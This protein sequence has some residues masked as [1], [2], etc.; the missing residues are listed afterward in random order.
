VSLPLEGRP[1]DEQK[2]R[3]ENWLTELKIICRRYRILL[4][5]DDDWVHIVDMDARTTIGIGLTCLSATR[6]GRERITAYD[7]TGSILDGVWL[8][9]TIDGP[10]EQ[11]TVAPVWPRHPTRETPP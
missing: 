10:A 4:D 9:D 7:C 1:T 11:R 6:D 5:T 8:V 2:L 3:L